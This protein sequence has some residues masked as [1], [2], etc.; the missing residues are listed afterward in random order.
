[1]SSQY[2]SRTA[3][4]FAVRLPD[5]LRAEIESAACSLDTSMN[6]V[7]VRALRQYLDD[8]NRQQL[9]LDALVRAAENKQ[10]TQCAA[11]QKRHIA[12]LH[13]QIAE[14]KATQLQEEPVAWLDGQRLWHA[15]EMKNLDSN[16]TKRGC[17]PLYRSSTGLLKSSGGDMGKH[18]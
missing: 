4:K 13:Q 3:D 6:T 5:G 11:L 1:M 10:R 18:S 9:L 8:Q 17:E 16:P 14:L 7:F 15:E 2:D 12:S